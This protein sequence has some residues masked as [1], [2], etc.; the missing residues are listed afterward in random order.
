M[1]DRIKIALIGQGLRGSSLREAF[2]KK[3]KDVDIL[4]VCDEYEDKAEEGAKS[5]RE[6]KGDNPKV[7]TNY[8]EILADPEVQLVFIYTAWE[9][10]IRIAIDAMKAGKMTAME[11]GGAC[12]VEE[13]WE[14]V[15]TQEQTG[16]KLMFMENCCFNR[17]EVLALKMARAGLFGDIVH[18]SG[19]YSHDLR[20]EITE[21]NRIRHYRLRH[22]TARNGENYPTHELGPIAKILDIN[23]GN[24]MVSLV[25]M[26]SK[27]MGLK[28]YIKERGDE[29][30]PAVKDIDFKQGD[31]VNTIIKCANGETIALKLDTTIP[32]FYNR[33]LTVRG[34]MGS[35]FMQFNA[36]I[37]DGK[38]E[39]CWDP[40]VYTKENTNSADK[41]A[42]LLP[43]EWTNITQQEK[44]E[45]HGGMDAIMLRRI[46]RCVKTGEDF[47]LDV[48]DAA[49]W[50]V[51]TPLSEQ[52]IAMGGAPQAIP[53]F[54]SGEWVRRKRHD[55]F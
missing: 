53:D 38:E 7:V 18:C 12:S 8:K 10:H 33:D 35:Y 9:T 21:G 42:H 17:E 39:H 40:V 22:Y 25:S 46:I 37:V 20:N 52:S 27:A 44:D 24:R 36:A 55:V 32:G 15:R 5:I 34:T 43:P 29:A 45:G 31:I 1:D 4:Y 3:C 14:H 47:P 50:M 41:F 13:C 19:A 49:T 16:V 51:I 28:R 48:Y 6:F 2:F 26:A 54:T 23:R 30:D 11:V